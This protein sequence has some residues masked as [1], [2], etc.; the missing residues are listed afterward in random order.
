MKPTP[1]IAIFDIGKT[2]KK[3]F[4][5]NEQYQSEFERNTRFTETTDEDGDPCEHLES[6]RLFILDSLREVAAMKQFDL[7]AVNFTA[8]GASF[9]Y[10][11]ASGEPL[12]PLYNY[13]KPLSCCLATAVIRYS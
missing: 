9:V 12:T 1:V 2:N 7:K 13:L 4:L 10:I 3:L 8:Y 11:D 5:F 6:L